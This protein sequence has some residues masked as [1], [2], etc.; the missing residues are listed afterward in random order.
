MKLLHVNT[1]L[2]INFFFVLTKLH[3]TATRLLILVGYEVCRSKEKFY[4]KETTIHFR[5]KI[6][7][8]NI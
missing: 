4:L 5:L 6:R 2:H 1:P 8:N 3:T 7:T